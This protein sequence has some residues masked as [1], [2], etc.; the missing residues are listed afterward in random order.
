MKFLFL[1][2]L[3]ATSFL[4]AKSISSK[5]LK[6]HKDYKAKFGN[7]KA[8]VLHF[9]GIATPKCQFAI[10]NDGQYFYF[11]K[12]N[13]T[14]KRLINSKGDKI[15]CNSDKS[16]CKTRKELI[17]FLK[18]KTNNNLEN[19]TNE[20]LSVYKD[21]QAKFG[22]IEAQVLHFGG[23]ATPKCQFAI[24]N[25]GQYFYFT[26]LNSTCKRLKNSKGKKIVCNSNKSVCKTR[27]EL[28]EFI[29]YGKK[30]TNISKPSWCIANHLNPTEKT[31]CTNKELI[32]L[33]KKLA[34]VYGTS[35]ANNKDKEQIDW[36]K[37]KRNAC[38]I[39]V[40]CIR[41]A[42]DNRINQ[43]DKSDNNVHDWWSI[44]KAKRKSIAKKY[45]ELSLET[46]N[47]MAKSDTLKECKDYDEQDKIK[48]LIKTQLIVEP[49]EFAKNRYD[50]YKRKISKDT[51]DKLYFYEMV[52]GLKLSGKE[53]ELI[54]KY[55]PGGLMDYMSYLDDCAYNN[56][57]YGIASN[58]IRLHSPEKEKKISKEEMKIIDQMIIKFLNR[59][60]NNT[61]Q[62]Y[63][64][65]SNSKKNG[66]YGYSCSLLA[67]IYGGQ[68]K[69]FKDS[70]MN[71]DEALKIAQNMCYDKNHA[72]SCGELG[73]IL[74][75]KG[76]KYYQ[77]A[78]HAFQKGCTLTNT[79]D[80]HNI[81][82]WCCEGYKNLINKGW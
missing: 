71:I 72:E 81:C 20:D 78:K 75:D 50:D 21:Y 10:S 68:N 55:N 39:D 26:K 33:D 47:K 14:C 45:T 57:C 11:T 76:T 51:M 8:Q 58:L 61:L 6:V 17:S 40:G 31:I 54:S 66:C 22:S 73:N 59:G 24:S 27:T 1:S 3:V 80:S 38:G 48:Q 43:L 2:I 37:N 52:L 5:D 62:K 34:S 12:L 70:K 53:I 64:D 16:V 74:I 82:L 69:F 32:S 15:V 35:K 79:K 13:S 42:Y 46:I 7:I 44:F 41:S 65:C 29:K 23:V 63:S 56:K 28:V 60:C 77:Q 67:S 30:R 49:L 36:L 19:S 9:G 18:N 4:Q 25:D